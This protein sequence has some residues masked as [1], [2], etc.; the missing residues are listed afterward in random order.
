MAPPAPLTSSVPAPLAA[1]VRQLWP[2]AVFGA[3]KAD[4]LAKKFDIPE[5]FRMPIDPE[6]AKTIDVGAAETLE[7]DG[8][9]DFAKKIF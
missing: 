7:I 8:F 3:S 2:I 1:C 4:A 6:F 9:S 5:F